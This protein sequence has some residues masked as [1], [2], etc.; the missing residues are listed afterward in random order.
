[1]INPLGISNYQPQRGKL[2]GTLIL[3][4]NSAPMTRSELIATIAERFPHL[5]MK[6][7][8]VSVQEILSG[9]SS[10]LSDGNRVEIRGFGSF[11]LN[12]RPPRLGRNPKT[13][14]KVPVPGKYAPHFKAGKELA[15]L[16]MEAGKIP[17]ANNHED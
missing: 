6:D 4:E 17:P 10:A 3:K 16:V 7:A 13:G 2:P 11:S 12:Y 8:E 1:M 14:E 5:T 15:A 9:I